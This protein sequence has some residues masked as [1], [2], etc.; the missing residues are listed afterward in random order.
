MN[1]EIKIIEKPDWISWDDIKKCLFDAHA[2]NR[3]KGINMANYQWPAQK[4]KESIGDNGIMFVALDGDKLVG[5]AAL[6]EKKSY[7]WYTIGKCGYLCFDCVLPAYNGMGIYRSLMKTR[8]SLAKTL[9]YDVLFYDT[10]YKNVK[11]LSWGEKNGYRKVRYFLT[12]DNDH[13][14]IVMAKW[15][16]GCPYSNLYCWWKYSISM[17]KTMLKHLKPNE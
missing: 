4:I 14:S 17:V 10:H 7:H 11:V 5:T 6:A 1:N 15:L 16:K 9:D 3:E 13:H 12:K 2:K 8:E